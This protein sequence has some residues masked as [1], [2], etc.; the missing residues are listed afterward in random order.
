MITGSRIFKQV[1]DLEMISPDS[2]QHTWVIGFQMNYE[3]SLDTCLVRFCHRSTVIPSQSACISHTCLFS[4]FLKWFPF[5]STW[6]FHLKKDSK[7][8]STLVCHQK[9]K[10]WKTLAGSALHVRSLATIKMLRTL[11]KKKNY[12]M[13]D[14]DIFLIKRNSE[15]SW[16]R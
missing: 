14:H 7:I 8:K 5:C 3:N 6:N 12:C 2:S 13:L 16:R 4:K 9:G 15:N 11:A 1:F 10:F